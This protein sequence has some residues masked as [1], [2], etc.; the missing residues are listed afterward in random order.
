M[1]Y[2]KKQE[3]Q[4]VRERHKSQKV[5][6]CSGSFDLIHAGH[7][8]FFED[9][10]KHGDILVVMA[11]NDAVL[12][13]NKGPDRPVLNEHVRIKMIDSL[14]PVDYCL[15]DTV[16]DETTH[17]LHCLHEIFDDL[18][19]DVYVINDDAFDIP[20]REELVKKFST[21]LVVLP[22]TAPPE[23]ENISSTKI[24][25]KLKSQENK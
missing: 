22:R 20:Y 14:K 10:K 1:A 13:K 12:K 23:F 24:I 25:E 6:F 9:C 17:P 19:P 15:L 5:V 3:L 2:I 11:A 8:L 7:V 16:A 18:R 4:A 21:K